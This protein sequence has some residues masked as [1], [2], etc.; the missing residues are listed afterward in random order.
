M[1]TYEYACKEC[2]FRF[3]EFQSIVS[4][5]IRI[6]PKCKGEVERLINGGIGLIFRGSGF[7]LTDYK[8]SN[9]S[10]AT[11]S[12]TPDSGKDSKSEKAKTEKS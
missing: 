5:P 11:K 12:A 7:Y 1:P 6:C 3:E 2:G 9:S 4:E 10:G 8:N